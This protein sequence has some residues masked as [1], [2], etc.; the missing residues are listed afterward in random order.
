[1]KVGRL[2]FQTNQVE[3]R[4]NPFYLSYGNTPLIMTLDQSS[5][6]TGLTVGTADGEVKEIL[7]FIREKGTGETTEGYLIKLG[8]WLKAIVSNS[9][10][11]DFSNEAFVSTR[12]NKSDKV[13][14]QV[15]G[16]IKEVYASATCLDANGEKV[17]LRMN[18]VNRDINNK[19]WKSV[20]VP[21]SFKDM[22][23]GDEVMAYHSFASSLILPLSKMGADASASF[24]MYLY[25]MKTNYSSFNLT[26]DK[27][28]IDRNH[29]L[30]W[31][32]IPY[33]E[34]SAI[35]KDLIQLGDNIGSKNYNR[36]QLKYISEYRLAFVKRFF[37]ICGGYPCDDEMYLK[38]KDVIDKSLGT[39]L[40]FFTQEDLQILL[41]EVNSLKLQIQESKYKQ[42][43][44]N[45]KLSA[46]ENLRAFTGRNRDIYYS[47]V[48]KNLHYCYL[49]PTFN[50]HLG[51]NQKLILIGTNY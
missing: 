49:I 8:K 51:P 39:H 23:K 20:V 4:E 14:K 16:K 44:Y 42:F 40:R 9:N 6:C 28:H 17:L 46:E 29:N 50:L 22:H 37:S 24:C 13:T 12:Y 45:D 31:Y 41:N 5:T 10:V 18:A 36:E 48:N 38:Y 43:N 33:E 11:I 15:L 1:M 7:A 26:P 21:K 34:I 3:L 19:T 32:A 35:D 30:A 27:A 2:N 47:V 25:L